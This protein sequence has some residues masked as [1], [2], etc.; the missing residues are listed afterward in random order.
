MDLVC[1]DILYPPFHIELLGLSL[2]HF[3]RKISES[4]SRVYTVQLDIIYLQVTLAR[5]TNLL[6]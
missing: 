3:N 1:D 4:C 6:C 2:V 5:C